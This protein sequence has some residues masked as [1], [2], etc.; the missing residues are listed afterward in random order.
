LVNVQQAVFKEYSGKAGVEWTVKKLAHVRFYNMPEQ[1]ITHITSARLHE[2]ANKFV[3]FTATVFRTGPRK[4][5]EFRK[6]FRCNKC[7]YSFWDEAQYDLFYNF[8]INLECPNITRKGNKCSGRLLT[9]DNG[10]QPEN[11]L[12]FR[13]IHVQLL[14]S[15]RTLKSIMITLDNDLTDAC[16]CGDTVTIVGVIQLRWGS[17]IEGYKADITLA[18]QANSVKVIR[19]SAQVRNPLE[20]TTTI[21]NEWSRKTENMTEGMARDLLV[22]SICPQVAGMYYVKLSMALVLASCVERLKFEEKGVSVRSQV[23]LLLIG[24]PGV[25]KSVLLGALAKIASISV[26]TSGL[27]STAAGLTAAAI[28]VGILKC[29]REKYNHCL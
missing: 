15:K 21:Y 26:S 11:C 14:N 18:I 20:F 10:L 4:V 25:A 29:R 12:D 6:E 13:E 7:S 3:Q 8:D 1:E 23:H 2:H 28:K 5:L 17:F 19:G 9:V 16:N 27:G 24:D 22:K